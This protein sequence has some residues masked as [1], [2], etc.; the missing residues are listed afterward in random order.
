MFCE[1]SQGETIPFL[2][3]ENHVV[4][5]LLSSNENFEFATKLKEHLTVKKFFQPK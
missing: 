3:V 4:A 2:V 1:N 5:P